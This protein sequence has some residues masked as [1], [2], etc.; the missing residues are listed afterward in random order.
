MRR[1]SLSLDAF[2]SRRATDRRLARLTHDI[3]LPEGRGLEFGPADNST[4]LPE[5]LRVTYVDRDLDAGAGLPGAVPIDCAW[6]NP[7]ALV[8]VLGRDGYDFAIAGQVGQYVPDLLGWLRG[9]Y[10][11]LR[12]G[13]VLNLSLP[14]KRFTCDAARPSSTLAELVEAELLGLTRPSPRQVFAHAYEVRSITPAQ[15]WDGED[16]VRAPRMAGD[17]ALTHARAE[18]AR[19][20]SG[21]Y[22]PS[23]CWVVTA[24][25]FLDLIEGATRLGLLPFVLNQV[26][27]L[28]P[29]GF[30][31]YVSMRRDPETDPNALRRLQEGAI[32]YL[33]NELQRRRAA[34]SLLGS[35]AM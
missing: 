29:G 5:G 20:V 3:G 4:P 25:S 13:G 11:A 16:P 7:G 26:S 17:A 15:I 6:N 10:T 9:I 22:V 8:D 30:E 24:I 14:D 1:G 23:H 34:A 27:G 21:D 32:T 18:A 19:A 31:F 35:D 2:L 12:P 33:R 28:E